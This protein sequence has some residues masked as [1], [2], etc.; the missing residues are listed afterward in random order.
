[1][2]RVAIADSHYECR[3][4]IRQ[5]LERYER[6]SGKRMGI[7]LL[8]GGD[9]LVREY[10]YRSDFD[11]VIIGLD[12]PKGGGM[13]A[14]AEVR[15]MDETVI[16]ILIA[17]GENLDE[18]REGYRIGAFDFIVKPLSDARLFETMDRAVSTLKTDGG[19]AVMIEVEDGVVKLTEE[20]I[21]FAEEKE[22]TLIYHTLG[23]D[24]PAKG[25]IKDAEKI[26]ASPRFFKCAENLVVNLDFVEGIRDGYLQIGDTR[27]EIGAE[28]G[29]KT[30]NALNSYYAGVGI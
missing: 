24:Q 10:Q 9:M 16:L 1:M 15:G 8:G 29:K 6:T 21:S 27:L 17:D 26:L 28:N 19:R 14:A 11:I 4:D 25:T 5:R 2:I 12:T 13:E 18:I 3:Q 20:R 22:N 30:L 23:G 7:S